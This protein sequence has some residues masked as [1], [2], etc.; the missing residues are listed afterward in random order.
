LGWDK[1]YWF[2]EEIKSWDKIADIY[3][4]PLLEFIEEIN[5]YE[6]LQW[7]MRCTR[8]GYHNYYIPTQS[9]IHFANQ[10]LLE[11]LKN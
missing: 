10:K 8:L 3:C 7:Q 1:E 9:C 6:F 2:I 5:E 11:F 4:S